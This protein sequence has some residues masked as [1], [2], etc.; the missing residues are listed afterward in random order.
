MDI[1]VGDIQ[2][3]NHKKLNYNIA[4]K[5]RAVLRYLFNVVKWQNHRGN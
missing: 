1:G 5:P 2:L 3:Y 4:D